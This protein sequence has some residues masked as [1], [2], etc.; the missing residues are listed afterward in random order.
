[1]NLDGN[2]VLRKRMGIRGVNDKNLKKH[3]E[4]ISSSRAIHLL[5]RLPLT[6]AAEGVSVVTGKLG[7]YCKRLQDEEIVDRLT[8]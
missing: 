6:D 8:W 1:M 5:G 3:G 2:W 7:A 4:R